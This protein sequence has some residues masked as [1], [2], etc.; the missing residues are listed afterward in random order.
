MPELPEVETVTSE[1]RESVVG[2]KITSVTVNWAG[3]IASPAPDE[4]AR[5]LAGQT[6]LG[7]SRRGKWIIVA[8]DSGQSLLIHLRMT[9]RLLVAEHACDDE[10]HARVLIALGD[11]RTLCFTD[12]RKFGR[13][14]LVD[15]P[16]VVVGGLGL[17]PLG[18]DF[19]ADRLG[20]MLATRRG[21]IKPLLL[22]QGFLAGLGNIYTDEALWQARIHPLRR[23]CSLT[24]AEVHRLHRAIR[25]VLQHA[26][27]SRG[28]TLAD[29]GF[30]GTS[31]EPGEFAAL[32]AV[33]G[34]AGGP[35]P[36]CRRLI[37]RI[38]VSQRG[39]HLCPHCQSPPR[40]R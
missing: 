6:I 17:E 23:A 7:A 19:T 3:A 16:T 27:V 21:R 36:R 12:V 26:T 2:S 18:D 38:R 4:F 40:A 15:D 22:N 13:L 1:L 14:W 10:S 34:R 37:E 30:V 25:T 20:E 24:R 28:T 11:G 31:G 5:R 8:L 39:T 35:C 32:L 33:Y 9:G 29:G